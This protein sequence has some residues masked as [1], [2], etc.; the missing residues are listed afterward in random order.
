VPFDPGPSNG[1]L[2][3]F[4][5]LDRDGWR[6]VA[7]GLL[8][9]VLQYSAGLTEPLRLR[10]SA[11][12]G[13]PYLS[14]SNR[15]RGAREAYVE[16]VARTML[17]AACLLADEPD[18]RVDGRRVA[19]YY[20]ELLLRGVRAAGDGSF[21]RPTGRWPDQRTVEAALVTIAL[22]QAPRALWE[23][24]DNAGRSAVVDWLADCAAAPVHD[25]NWRWFPVLTSTFVTQNGGRA[26]GGAVAAHLERL[27]AMHVDEGWFRDGDRFDFYSG[28]V[29]QC[30]PI[31]WAA[32]DGDSRPDLR[33]SFYRLND[34]FLQT[35]PHLFS[36]RGFMPAWGRSLC[37]RYAASAPLSVA[38][39]RPM[40]PAIEPGFARRLASG[41]LLQFIGRDDV[42]ADGLLTL[43]F[44]G[45]DAS[46]V[47]HYSCTASPYWAALAFLALSLPADNAY[48][49]ATESEGFWADPPAGVNFGTTGLRAEH[50]RATGATRLFAPQRDRQWDPRYGQPYYEA[51]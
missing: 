28:W 38:F 45:Q 42:I 7:H 40:P 29:M 10:P 43:G 15:A 2:S 32:W 23:P 24:L 44:Y 12:A 20:L 4:S 41:N 31:L 6:R 18:L 22:R 16:G 33:D 35:Y 27:L 26:D 25:S 11:A 34:E 17:L 19:D 51:S 49:T 47:D 37:Y 48:W 30:C 3:P 39:L 46:V 36:R 13:Y 21:G 8:E 14:L 5:G 50:D 9:N 1:Q